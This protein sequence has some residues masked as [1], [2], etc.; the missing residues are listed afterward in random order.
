MLDL[1]AVRAGL[2][3]PL[4]QLGRERIGWRGRGGGRGPGR[5]RGNI[6]ELQVLDPSPPEIEIDAHLVDLADRGL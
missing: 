5:R 1:I 4:V 6:Q 2:L 3:D